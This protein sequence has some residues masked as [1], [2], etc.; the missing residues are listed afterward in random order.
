[1]IKK[2]KDK[3]LLM[4]KKGDK[5]LGEGTYQEMVKREKQVNYFKSLKKKGYLK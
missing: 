4:S 2:I 3:Y 1:M 5:K